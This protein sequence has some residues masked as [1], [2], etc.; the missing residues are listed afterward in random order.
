LALELPGHE[1]WTVA[2][3]GWAGTKNG[4]LLKRASE[5]F[6]VF[7]TADQSLP[8]QQNLRSVDLGIILLRSVTNRLEALLPLVPGLRRC[9]QTIQPGEIVL[10]TQ[11][12]ESGLR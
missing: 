7:V 5:V 11:E 8:Y 10:V 1:V 9:L 3:R 12:G 4:E 6:D 2:Q